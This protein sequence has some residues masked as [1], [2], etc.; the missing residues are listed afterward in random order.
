MRAIVRR[1]SGED[2]KAYVK[3]VA[4]PDGVEIMNDG[5]LSRFDVNRHGKGV[6]K[7]HSTSPS[8]PDAKITNMKDGRTHL[9]YKAQHAVD[10]ERGLALAATVRRATAPDGDTLGVSVPRP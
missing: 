3:Q 2:W 9:A 10:L 4:A 8:D 6:S 1:D 7:K 5:D